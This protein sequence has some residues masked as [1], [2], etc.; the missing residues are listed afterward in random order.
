MNDSFAKD[1]CAFIKSR[2]KKKVSIETMREDILDFTQARYVHEQTRKP[3]ENERYCRECLVLRPLSDF[4]LK[5][6]CAQC[7]IDEFNDDPL[8]NFASRIVK[9]SR[10]RAERNNVLFSITEFDV[11]TLFKKQGGK[12]AIS[13]IPLTL[14]Y[15]PRG[16]TKFQRMY[17]LSIDQK[18]P[19]RGYTH[20]NS[21][22]VCFQI[23]VMK[24]DLAQDTFIELC[25]K[26]SQRWNPVT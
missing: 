19:G 2:A 23:N 17:N 11:V 16:L 1:L 25:S 18:V 9:Q 6:M 7:K 5:N 22:L 21:Q 10:S 20:Q 15:N 26:V 4:I 13:G 12:C 8:L 24:L 14:N 3:T